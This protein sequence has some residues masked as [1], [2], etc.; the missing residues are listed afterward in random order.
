M[1]FRI[2]QHVT[3]ALDGDKVVLQRGKDDGAGEAN[4]NEALYGDVRA[5]V[6]DCLCEAL[7]VQPGATGTWMATQ[8]GSE[9][10][11]L[12]L[13]TLNDLVNVLLA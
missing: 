7:E 6:H 4:N 1:L 8:E 5:C 3:L 9:T 10:L 12:H 11:H 13:S 2:G